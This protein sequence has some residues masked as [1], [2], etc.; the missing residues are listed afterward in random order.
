MAISA[1]RFKFLDEETNVA[2]S[3]F[4]SSTGSDILN[5]PKKAAAAISGATEAIAKS[6]TLAS[7][8]DG[9]KGAQGTLNS[10]KGIV[11]TVRKA[12]DIISTIQKTKSL[13]LDQIDKLASTVFGSGSPQLSAFKTLGD[14]V[15]GAIASGMAIESQLKGK[16]KMGE[17]IL[18]AIKH[19]P[20]DLKGIG[21]LVT[22]L[23]DGGYGATL[24]TFL[25]TKNLEKGITGVIGPA[26]RMGL[27]GTFDAVAAKFSESK[28]M[29][30]QSAT[31]LFG[32][33]CTDKNMFG[34]MELANSSVGSNITSLMPDAAKQTLSNF[35]IPYGLGEAKLSG[36]YT[37]FT[38][39]LSKLDTSWSSMNLGS[40]VINSVSNFGS[41]PNQDLDKVL[42]ADFCTRPL[43][44]S[45]TEAVPPAPMS[46]V[47][48]TGYHAATNS[49]T[50]A[51]MQASTSVTD[52]IASTTGVPDPM[53]LPSQ[54]SIGDPSAKPIPKASNIVT[55]ADGTSYFH[56]GIFFED[57][58]TADNTP[59]TPTKPVVSNTGSASAAAIAKREA[60]LAALEN[61]IAAAKV[62]AE[63]AATVSTATTEYN[64]GMAAMHMS[65]TEEYNKEAA[66][67]VKVNTDF[68]AKMSRQYDIDNAK[69]KKKAKK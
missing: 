42:Q 69:S 56:T 55:A 63:S 41:E 29:L 47:L 31:S 33:S 68:F 24:N 49:A 37:D 50:A 36:F 61:K 67:E 14:T 64:Y 34:V 7:I 10:L 35:S 30:T 62:A 9:I 38:S 4:T 17:S 48:L 12:K 39:S 57:D 27:P 18:N 28:D 25:D 58:L 59:I 32:M 60:D 6:S 45:D 11:S 15:K 2:V 21:N 23:S 13:S 3:D 54:I 19:P 43:D 51:L 5:A 22:K 1:E 66:A 16:L 52:F 20:T 53:P 65:M 26:M 8:K 44:T 40:T 46:A